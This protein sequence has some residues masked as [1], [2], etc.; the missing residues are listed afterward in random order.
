MAS[1]EDAGRAVAELNGQDLQGRALTVS[2]AHERP[3]GVGRS[4]R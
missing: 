1:A 4:G 2:E 3:A